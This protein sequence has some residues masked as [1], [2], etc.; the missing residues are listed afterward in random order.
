MNV[1]ADRRNVV[2][3][4][5]EYVHDFISATLPVWAVYHSYGH[6]C[7]VVEACREIGTASG[8]NGDEVEMLMLAGWFHDAGY[9]IKVEG[10]EEVGSEMAE[11]FLAGNKYPRHKIETIVRC[12]L[13]T[14]L[15]CTPVTLMEKIIKDADL[16]SLGR[17]DYIEKNNL[18]RSEMEVRDKY[19]FTEAE[20]LTRSIQFLSSHRYQT[21]YARENYANQVEKNLRT[22]QEQLARAV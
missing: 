12:I 1:N 22:L 13:A 7:E 20:W 21:E 9:S 6:T 3:L 17:G 8:L 15:T 5:S 11:K 19:K 2:Q 18:L 4:S 10:H 14:K 16:I